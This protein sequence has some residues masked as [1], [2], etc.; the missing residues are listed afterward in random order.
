MVETANFDNENGILTKL[1]AYLFWIVHLH[2]TP[3]DE[4]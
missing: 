3:I 2:L 1:L 4:I